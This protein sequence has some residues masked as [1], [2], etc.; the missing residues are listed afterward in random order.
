MT[1]SQYHMIMMML[2][3]NV[4]MVCTNYWYATT[5]LAFLIV[6]CFSFLRITLSEWTAKARAR[7]EHLLKEQQH[8]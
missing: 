6:H 3:L 8:D 7:R 1:I 5:S 2:W 4:L